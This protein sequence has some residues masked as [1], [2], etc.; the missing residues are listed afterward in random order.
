VIKALVVYGTRYGA[1]A[2]TSEVIAGVLRQEGFEV[3]IVDAKKDKVQSISEFVLV[4]VGSGIK[5]GKWTKEPE[6]FLGK[7][8]KE[9]LKKKVALFVC[10][11]SA[12]PLTE[13]EEKTR[14]MEKGKRKYLEDKAV[15]YNL[16]LIALGFFGGIFDFNKLSWFLRK[17]LSGVKLK[18]E[19]AG[20]KESKSGI[21]DLRNLV[22]IRSWAKD[23]A[24]M[25][26]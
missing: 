24:Q 18:L 2:D 26:K 13:G 19:E 16:N 7:F 20:F 4:I 12:K 21:Y 23:V 10:C 3:R 6:K 22:T 25:V 5:M 8:Q 15:H 1:T 14:E 9:L 11:G 17:T